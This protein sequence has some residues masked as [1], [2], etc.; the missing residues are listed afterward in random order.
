MFSDP[1][2]S[3]VGES[4]VQLYAPLQLTDFTQEAAWFDFSII[5][6]H[7]PLLILKSGTNHVY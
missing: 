2:R 3:Y 6:A 5:G 4:E 1:D 7:A